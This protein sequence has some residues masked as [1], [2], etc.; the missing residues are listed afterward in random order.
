[1]VDKRRRDVQHTMK[2]TI[3][4]APDDYALLVRVANDERVP[5]AV[6]VRQ[7]LMTDLTKR[8]AAEVSEGDAPLRGR[9]PA[10]GPADREAPET[11]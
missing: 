8:P 3:R 4:L 2:V 5:V 10:G 9:H 11:P 6:L 1:L 7:I